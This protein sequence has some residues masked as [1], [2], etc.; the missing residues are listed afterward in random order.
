[1]KKIL[2]VLTDTNIGGAGIDL[3]N[4]LAARDRDDFE[5][6]VVLPRGAALISSVE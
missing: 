1:M 2:Q 5:T 4:Y 6:A 3:L